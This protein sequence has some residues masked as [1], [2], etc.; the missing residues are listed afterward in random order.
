MWIIDKSWS[1]NRHFYQDRDSVWIC[2]TTCNG[3]AYPNPH[4]SEPS[5]SPSSS[6]SSWL[7]NSKTTLLRVIPAMENHDEDH[8]GTSLAFYLTYILACFWHKHCGILFGIYPEISSTILSDIVSVKYFG[9]L[10]GGW[11]PAVLTAL[12]PCRFRSS[13]AHCDPELAKRIGE[14]LG[15]QD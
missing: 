14:K 13:G 6:S 8:G 11:G 1:I 4:S 15:E 9:I 10:F 7:L 2:L 5:N 12:G 3:K